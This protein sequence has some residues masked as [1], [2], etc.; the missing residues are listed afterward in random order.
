MTEAQKKAN[1]KY[2]QSEKGILAQK[3]AQKKA[4]KKRRQNT[5]NIRLP[6]KVLAMLKEV[7]GKNNAERILRLLENF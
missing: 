7:E 5:T 3:K 4:N 1:Q 6:K 2:L